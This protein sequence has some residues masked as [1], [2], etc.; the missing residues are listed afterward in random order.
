M[1]PRPQRHRVTFTYDDYLLFPNDGK[2]HEIMDGEHYM[3]PAPSTKHQRI[4]TN[5]VRILASFLKKERIGRVYAAPCDVV[6]S[7]TDVVEPDLLFVSETRMAIIRD[8]HI[9]GA[10]DL[11]VEI[12]SER[13]RKTDE[14][15]KRKLYELHGVKEYWIVDPVLEA[16]KIYGM[17]EQGYVRTA[18]LSVESRDRLS[19]S[20]LPGLVITLSEIFE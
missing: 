11:V 12:L 1:S 3:T 13:T 4:S 10:P 9:R 20:L 17:K 16:L 19:T 18:E 8:E 7:E 5:F 14:V 15:I 6:L 2:R